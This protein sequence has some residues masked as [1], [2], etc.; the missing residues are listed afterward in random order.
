[1]ASANPDKTQSLA[2]LLQWVVLPF[3]IGFL[4]IPYF[5]VEFTTNWNSQLVAELSQF[6]VQQ[7]PVL[8]YTKILKYDTQNKTVQLYCSFKPRTENVILEL[9]KQRDKWEIVS[10]QSANSLFTWPVY[11]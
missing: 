11:L 6:C 10:T 4:A 5:Q 2:P 3:I 8:K 7:H 9:A 1:M